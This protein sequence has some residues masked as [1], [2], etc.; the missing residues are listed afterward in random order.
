MNTRALAI[1]GAAAGIGRAIALRFLTDGW[2]VGAFDLD[3]AGLA[4]L[5]AD[6]APLAGRVVTGTLDV[7][8]RAAFEERLS[9][10][11]ADTGRLDVMINNA[12]VLVAGQFADL[13]AAALEREIGVNVLGV[14]HG[15]H[16]AFPHLRATPGSVAVNLASASAIYGQAELAN[17]SATKFYVR[18]LTEALNLEWADHG[19]RVVD[20]W[21]LFVETGMLTDVTTGTTES[22]GV[23][24]S[25]DDVADTV[26]QAVH[27]NAVQRLSRQV[28]FAVGRQ[29]RVLALGS[30]FSP[31]WLTRQVNKRLAH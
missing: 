31:A 19:V 13:D 2:T 10:F 20:L 15:M 6:A 16:L 25:A 26:W 30:R 29:A 23:R 21:P 3:A 1:T 11:V 24:L 5:E 14:M 9:A 18:G 22:L 27:P 28:H 12:G 17:Y 7:R 4:A 8:D